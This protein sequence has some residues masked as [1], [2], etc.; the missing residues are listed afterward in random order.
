MLAALLTGFALSQAFRTVTAILAPGLQAEFGLTAR[1]LGAFA[2]LFGLSFGVA[3]LLMG[4]ALDL[5]GLRRT[6]LSALAVATAG[7]AL[8]ALAPG[9]GWLM[10]G[11]LLIGVGC[12][13]AFLACA[14]FIS[15]HLPS[16]RFAFYSGVS[17]GSGGLGLLFTG[18]P[19]AWVVQHS[20]W[21]AGFWVLTGLCML[22]WL[23]I[24]RLVHEP[25]PLNAPQAPDE[26]WATALSRL[27]GLLALP[28]TWG[29]LALGASSYAAFLALRGLWLGPLLIDRYGFS[30]VD[31]GNVAVVLS[32]ISLFMPGLFGRMDPGVA[33]RRRWVA[34]CALLAAL[35]FGLMAFLHHAGL[36]VA[37]IVL[38]GVLSGYSVLQYTDVRSSYPPEL[39]ARALSL[40]TMVMFLGAAL[41]QWFTGLVAT[42]A[43]GLGIEPY[44]AV[45]LTMAAWLGLAALAFRWLPASPLLERAGAG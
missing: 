5:Y 13:P 2:G 21:R 24:W 7:A 35:L 29:I 6:V 28:Y 41:M 26:G 34:N 22:S 39:T 45:L 25:R 3:Q 38:M 10:A 8:S 17:L 1:S 20:S 27:A 12:S 16:E 11:Q 19:L 42:W 14:L 33:R 31:S 30:L 18:T 23:L 37:L 44:L 43:A 4:V 32:F 15:R 36:N 9:Y 40:F